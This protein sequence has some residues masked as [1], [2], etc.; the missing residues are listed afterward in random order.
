MRCEGAPADNVYLVRLV[1]SAVFELV[2]LL[3]NGRKDR[4]I[5]TLLGPLARFGL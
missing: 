3:D 5:Q 2:R 1:A 4:E